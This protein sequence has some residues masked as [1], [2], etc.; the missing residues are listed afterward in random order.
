MKKTSIFWPL[1]WRLTV[2]FLLCSFLIIVV[3]LDDFSVKY[4]QGPLEF[5]SFATPFQSNPVSPG[6]AGKV[7]KEKTNKRVFIWTDP[8]KKKRETVFYIPKPTLKKEIRKFGT[9]PRGVSNPF[10]LKKKGFKIV[11]KRNVMRGRRVTQRLVS[12]VDYKQIYERNLQYFKPLTSAL[13]E[14]AELAANTDPL[15][16]FLSF[17]QHI[18]Y[19]QPPNRYKG[20][21]INSFFVPLVCLDEQYGDCD[22]KSLL[23]AVFLGTR[24]GFK[25]KTAMVL[26]RGPGI[27]HA[28][29][30]VNR[31]PLPGMFRLFDMK[32]GFYVPVETTKPGWYVGFLSRRLIETMKSGYFSVVELN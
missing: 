29:L 25:Q 4:D 30:A 27:A 2:V 5:R 9:S 23:L 10:F 12:V 28:V 11:G 1:A 17:V 20:R 13:S 7:S 15:G 21:F 18:R 3:N 26:I 8:V 31:K 32:T 6:T 16:I 22:S 14:S 24:P 19:Q